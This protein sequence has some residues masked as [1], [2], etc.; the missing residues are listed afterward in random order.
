VIEYGRS[1]RDRR[2]A[3]PDARVDAAVGANRCPTRDLYVRTDDRIRADLDVVVDERRR[4]ILQRHA[5][6]HERAALAVADDHAQFR[7]LDTR[8]DSAKF[9]GIPDGERLKS[10]LLLSIQRHEVGQVVLALSV[11]GAQRRQALKQ[12][13]DVECVDA[14]VDLP[15]QPL[16]SGRIA[17]F[18][19]PEQLAPVV[20]HDPA[21]PVRVGEDG[22]EHGAG[23][24]CREVMLHEPLQCGLPQKRNV[25]VEQ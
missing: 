8:V 7:Q 10:Q 15:N 3:N 19:D 1:F 21:V 20:A 17:F 18:N 6:E 14:T 4:W 23:R 24:P 11:L 9:R 16:V 22:R 13:F 12:R 2:V 25:A 5:A